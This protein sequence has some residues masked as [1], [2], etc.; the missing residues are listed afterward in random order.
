M[1]YPCY[2]I[3]ALVASFMLRS[4][5]PEVFCKIRVLKNF[6]KVTRKLL[7]QRLSFNKVAGLSAATLLKESLAQVFSCKICEISQNTFFYR[8]PPVAA[9][10]C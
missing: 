2:K 1:D 3:N 8:T 5:R 6:V 10:S 7:C 4:S 9:S